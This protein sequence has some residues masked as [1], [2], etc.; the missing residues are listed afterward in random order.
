MGDVGVAVVFQHSGIQHLRGAH[1]VEFVKFTAHVEALGDFNGPVAPE[2]EENHAVA[3]LHG[4]H[5][6]AVL[7]NDEGGQI[8]VDHM[9]LLP[10]GF[11]RFF[12]RSKLPSFTQYMGVPALFHHAPVGFVPIHGDLHSASAGGNADVKIIGAQVG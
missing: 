6:L 12:C 1:P 5:R 2:V 8:L 10:V 11:N 3:V 4:A 9:K 7:S